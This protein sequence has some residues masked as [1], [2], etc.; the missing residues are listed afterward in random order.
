MEYYTDGSGTNKS[1]SVGVSDDSD[2]IR[3]HIALGQD[4]IVLQAKVLAILSY[5]LE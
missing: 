1:A 3:R 2:Q 5:G 4:A